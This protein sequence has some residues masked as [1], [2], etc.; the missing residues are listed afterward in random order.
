MIKLISS[1][2]RITNIRIVR[3]METNIQKRKVRRGEFWFGDETSGRGLRVLDR[4]RRLVLIWFVM[5][6]EF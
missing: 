2:C 4:P 5:S 6:L 3:G 1:K